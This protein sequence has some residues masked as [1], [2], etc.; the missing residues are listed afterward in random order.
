MII[1]KYYKSIPLHRLTYDKLQDGLLAMATEQGFL[2]KEV[3]IVSAR[4]LT[5]E[6]SI[7]HPERRDFPLVKGREVMIEATFLG[8]K[9]QAFTDTPGDF[10]GSIRDILALELGDELGNNYTRGVFVATLNAVLRHLGW[11][12]Y[13]VHCRNEEPEAC[14]RALVNYVKKQVSEPRIAFVGLQPA[15]VDYLARHYPI[16]VTDLDPDNLGR[17]K[18]GVIIEHA[19]NTAE[20][21][22]WSN[23]VLATGSTM[24][25]NTYESILRD[26][27]VI[28]YGVTVA[29][30]SYFTGCHQYCFCGH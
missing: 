11:V 10:R 20:A 15:M 26:K 14:A 2:D 21:I 1:T 18:Y 29:G 16:R 4:T 9:G 8:G 3:H 25:N 12:D 27:P 28:F 5:P 19:D 24:V 13:T 30:V 6:E 7:G 22:A 17:R 23:I